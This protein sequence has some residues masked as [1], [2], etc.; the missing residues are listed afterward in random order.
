MTQSNSPT[1]GASGASLPTE[2]LLGL[3]VP[4][5]LLGL[6]AARLVA[7]GLTQVGLASEQLFSGERLPNLNVPPHSPTHTPDNAN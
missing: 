2:V 1:Q 7:D 3:L 4:P 6:F 5:V